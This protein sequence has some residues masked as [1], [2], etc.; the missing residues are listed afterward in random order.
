MTIGWVVLQ[1][2]LDPQGVGLLAAGGRLVGEGGGGGL[3]QQ[4]GDD[5]PDAGQ[6]VAAGGAGPVAVGACWRRLVLLVV[7]VLA[8]LLALAGAGPLGAAV[9]AALAVRRLAPVLAAGV[10]AG[11]GPLAGTVGG[12]LASPG[13]VDPLA[14]RVVGLLEARPAARAGPPDGRRHGSPTSASGR[15][16]LPETEPWRVGSAWNSASRARP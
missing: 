1:A 15:C 6:V 8:P 14:A 12:L 11:A 9:L 3:A 2:V 4:G 16:P 5:A 10:L 13:A 7:A